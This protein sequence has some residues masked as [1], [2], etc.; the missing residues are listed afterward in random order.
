MCNSCAYSISFIFIWIQA[1]RHANSL[2]A[3]L[4]LLFGDAVW[5]GSFYSYS[6]S[7][8]RSPQAKY[9][10]YPMAPRTMIL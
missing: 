9:P 4:T 5:R 1:H 3:E 6:Y 10:D 8:S 2:R 7:L